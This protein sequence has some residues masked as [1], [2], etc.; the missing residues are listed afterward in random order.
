MKDIDIVAYLASSE[1]LDLHGLTCDEARFEL[2]RTL[3][4]VDTKTKAVEVVHGYHRGRALRDLVRNEFEHPLV[5]Q[6][7]KLDPSRTLLV[8]DFDRIFKKK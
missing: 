3:N 6:K 4:L 2:L 5:V 1:K 8:L 7:V